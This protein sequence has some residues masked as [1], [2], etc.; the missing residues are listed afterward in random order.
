MSVAE[1]TFI[2][3]GAALVHRDRPRG[4]DACRLE[5]NEPPQGYDVLAIDAFSGDSIPMHLITREAMALYVRHLKPDGVIV[6]RRPTASSTSIRWSS[7]SRTS[8]ECKRF[9]YRTCRAFRP[10]SEY[11][12][13]ATDQ[14]LV[15]RNQALLQSDSLRYVA[16]PIEDRR[17][18]M[19]TFTD[20]HHNMFRV[21]K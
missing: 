17:A 11:W 16:T 15:T 1:F 7:A 6:S 18:R 21:I 10:G 5:R 8:S 4:T 3:D 20:S 9:W 2:K 19:P 12:L 13:S 14:I